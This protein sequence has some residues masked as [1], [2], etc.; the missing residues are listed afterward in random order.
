MDRRPGRENEQRFNSCAI[1]DL[2]SGR[3]ADAGRVLS[4][5]A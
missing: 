4:S 1:D 3:S 2:R 5:G